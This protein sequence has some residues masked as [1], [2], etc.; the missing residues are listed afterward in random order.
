[1]K[2]IFLTLEGGLVQAVEGLPDDTELVVMDFDTQGA[3][4][5]DIT[6]WENALRRKATSPK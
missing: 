5:E 4:D 1:M 3:D 2:Y 6:S